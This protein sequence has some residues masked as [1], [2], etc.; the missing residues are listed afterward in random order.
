MTPKT[1]S[2]LELHIAVFLFGFTAILGEVI[3]LHP[4]ALTWWRVLLASLFF[5]FV[6]RIIKRVKQIPKRLILIYLGI[7]GIVAL[8]WLTFY[9]SIKASN[10]SITLVC[11]ATTTF[12]TA[13]IEP[14]VMKQKVSLLQLG[15]GI[16]ILPG[17]I[18][19]VNSTG[20]ENHWGIILGITSAILAAS[21]GALNKKWM[22]EEDPISITL[23]EMV[24]ATLLLSLC[25]PFIFQSTE[26]I[27]FMPSTMDW[28][29]LIILAVIC[30]NIAYLLALRALRH[31]T[32]YTTALTINLE[33]LYGILLA[34]I[35]LGQH[36]ELN[37]KFYVGAAIILLSVIGY[38]VIQKLIKKTY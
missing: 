14:A 4:L 21:F 13:L 17:M 1:K 30:T 37:I 26:A 7:G 27:K 24:A 3:D 10:A 31:L 16:I 32:A 6:P 5:L 34:A 18:L 9:A 11:L 20:S 35:L 19:I 25:I 15:I 28:L 22:G 2:F 23:I 8:H 12:F 33:P 36:N 29:Y 38:P